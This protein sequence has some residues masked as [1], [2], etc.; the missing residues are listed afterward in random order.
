MQVQVDEQLQRTV[1]PIAHAVEFFQLFRA[2]FLPRQVQRDIL[3]LERL[4]QRYE[5]GFEF[6]DVGLLTHCQHVAGKLKVLHVVEAAE[7][8]FFYFHSVLR[9]MVSN[10]VSCRAATGNLS[11]FWNFVPLR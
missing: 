4:L 7:P 6:F 8:H 1:S 3:F 10:N 2:L 11:R 9:L 5:H